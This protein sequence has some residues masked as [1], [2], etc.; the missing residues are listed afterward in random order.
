LDIIL[1]ALASNRR[2]ATEE[3]G[4]VLFL[5]EI[6][7]KTPNPA[8]PIRMHGFHVSGDEFMLELNGKFYRVGPKKVLYDALRERRLVPRNGKPGR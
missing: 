1:D 5:V 6:F 3:R 4:V 7:E 2:Q 8:G